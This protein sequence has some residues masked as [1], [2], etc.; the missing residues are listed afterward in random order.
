MSRKNGNGK[1]GGDLVVG[2][3]GAV[4]DLQQALAQQHREVQERLAQQHREMQET[5]ARHQK[6]TDQN[7]GRI[8]RMLVAVGDRLNDHERRLAAVEAKVR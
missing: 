1:H 7:L 6:A 3:H 2:L 8:A 5:L 4:V